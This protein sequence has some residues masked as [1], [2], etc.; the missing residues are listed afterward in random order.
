MGP[1]ASPNL[2]VLLALPASAAALLLEQV[3]VRLGVVALVHGGTKLAVGAA[4]LQR[5]ARAVLVVLVT[6]GLLALG[7][8]GGDGGVEG[9]G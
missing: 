5:V 8:G 2:A 3:W 7:F 6:G 9:C 4:R 1:V